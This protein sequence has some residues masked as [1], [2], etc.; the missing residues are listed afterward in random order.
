MRF[1]HVPANRSNNGYPFSGASREALLSPLFNFGRTPTGSLRP[2]RAFGRNDDRRRGGGSRIRARAGLPASRR[3][4]PRGAS[5][6]SRTFGVAAPRGRCNGVP[7]GIPPS[8]LHLRPRAAT[9]ACVFFYR[10]V[11]APQSYPRA[12]QRHVIRVFLSPDARVQCQLGRSP[13][14]LGP[15]LA[16]RGATRVHGSA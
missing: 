16:I 2:S 15:G 8:R 10:K 5:L 6:A 9:V 4:V 14:W 7:A 13:W 11:T 1:F 12:A 3:D